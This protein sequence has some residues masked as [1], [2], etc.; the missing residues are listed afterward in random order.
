MKRNM[1]RVSLITISIAAIFSAIAVPAV[2]Q[3]FPGVGTVMTYNVNE[4]TDLLQVVG[5]QTLPQFLL[6]VGEVLTQVQGTNPPERMRAVAREILKAQPE[7]VSLHRI[8]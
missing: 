3:S 4:G 2:A 7:L 5:A 1:T 6:G 8:V